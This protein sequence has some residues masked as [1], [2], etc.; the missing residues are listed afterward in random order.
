MNRFSELRIF[1]KSAV[2]VLVIFF[3]LMGL[4]TTVAY[5]RPSGSTRQDMSKAPLVR[6]QA[7]KTMHS[8]Q[9]SENP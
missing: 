3:G 9:I 5:S 8:E 7:V 6:Q 2:A 1:Q 4:V